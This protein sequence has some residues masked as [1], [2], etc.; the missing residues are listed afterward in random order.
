LFE[1]ILEHFATIEGLGTDVEPGDDAIARGGCR[2]GRLE[3]HRAVPHR[4]RLDLS[5]GPI[6]AS[7]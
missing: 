3:E 2:R 1:R 5:T 6:R 4:A 7:T